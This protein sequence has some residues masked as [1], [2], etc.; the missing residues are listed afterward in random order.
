MSRAKNN[1]I[2]QRRQEGKD[3]KYIDV[4]KSE[5]IKNQGNEIINK[6]LL[7]H[8]MG[9]GKVKKENKGLVTKFK[10]LLKSKVKR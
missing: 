5:H 8:A 4:M 2:K 6:G 3:N 10:S 9:M 7:D 1:R